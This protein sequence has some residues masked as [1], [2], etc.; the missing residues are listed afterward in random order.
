MLS[1]E[2]EAF[3]IEGFCCV[4]LALTRGHTELYVPT[5]WFIRHGMFWALSLWGIRGIILLTTAYS[6]TVLDRYRFSQMQPCTGRR[7][8]CHPDPCKHLLTVHEIYP[9]MPSCTYDWAAYS[10]KLENKSTPTFC[11]HSFR[12]L[13]KKLFLRVQ[14]IF[15]CTVTNNL[16]IYLPKSKL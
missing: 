9:Q 13:S 12:A 1:R 11:W 4:L 2:L 16:W 3:H 14:H 8:W 10:D 7:K 5:S 6:E 15:F